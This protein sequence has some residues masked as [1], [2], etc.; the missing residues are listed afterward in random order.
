MNVSSADERSPWSVIARLPLLAAGASL[1]A[2]LIWTLPGAA[3]RL[4]FDRA[5]IAAGEVWRVVSGH[6]THW[7]ADH[8]LWDVLMFAVLGALVERVSRAAFVITPLLSTLAISGVLWFWQ[9]TLDDYRGLSGIDSALFVFMAGWLVREAFQ[10]RRHAA[11]LLPALALLGFAGKVGYELVTGCTLFVDSMAA[12]FAPLPLAHVVGG[13][14]GAL[15][16]TADTVATSL[17]TTD[18]ASTC[19]WSPRPSR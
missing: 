11:L 17:T 9:P 12:G 16:L 18:A 19:Q 3:E 2:V 6:L 13:V 5:N 1:L 4:Q 14:V 7:N 8:L 10:E 15:V